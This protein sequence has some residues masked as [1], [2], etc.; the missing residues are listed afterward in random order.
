MAV[1]YWTS[2]ASLPISKQAPE[3]KLDIP[4]AEGLIEGLAHRV[5]W[6]QQGCHPLQDGPE[7]GG[8]KMIISDNLLP[9][10]GW[11]ESVISEKL[12]LQDGSCHGN[13]YLP[14]TMNPTEPTCRQLQSPPHTTKG[15]WTFPL[16]LKF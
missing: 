15:A 12:S 16:K 14:N 9:P 5:L 10:L 13:K 1:D 6:P 4:L 7:I 8:D 11:P 2:F 3:H